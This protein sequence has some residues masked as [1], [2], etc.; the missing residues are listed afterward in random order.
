MLGQP[1]TPKR[2]AGAIMQP[3]TNSFV[4]AEVLFLTLTRFRHAG[5]RSR[6]ED[7]GVF[8]ILPASA[9]WEEGHPPPSVVHSPF[10][11]PHVALPPVQR[12]PP[13][14]LLFHPLPWDEKNPPAEDEQPCLEVVL[15]FICIVL[16]REDKSFDLLD[17]SCL[18]TFC[19][20]AECR[21][22]RF[23]WP[24]QR[25]ILYPV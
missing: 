17:L 16:H 20:V 8:V 6:Y 2:G 9:V 23:T 21:K 7:G 11:H 4:A 18:K 5:R 22:V 10:T 13:P 1:P 25:S 3:L 19:G 12:R 24:G 14:V 15:V